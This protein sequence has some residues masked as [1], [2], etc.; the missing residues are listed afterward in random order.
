MRKEPPH[1]SATA[2]FFRVRCNRVTPATPLCIEHPRSGA[3]G[4]VVRWTTL[5][6]RGAPTEPAGETAS[7]NLVAS[8]GKAPGDSDS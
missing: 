8:T 5:A 2:P 3:E 4:A 6:K 1:V 7:S